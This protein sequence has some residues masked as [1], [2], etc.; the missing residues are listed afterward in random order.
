MNASAAVTTYQGLFDH[1]DQAAI[2]AD[3]RAYFG[4][5]ADRFIALYEKMR[6]REPAKRFGAR[7]WNWPAFFLTFVWF[8]YRRQW[9]YGIGV[10]VLNLV[11]AFVA[12]SA[13]GAIVGGMCGILA[14]TLYV[15]KAMMAVA[16]ADQAG[17]AGEARVAQL[18]AAGGVSKLAGGIAGFV[19]AALMALAVIGAVAG[20]QAAG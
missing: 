14:N 5:N 4:P 15:Q 19:L 20:Q 18:Q 8:F 16:A 6:G 13:A 3:L 12:G 2:Q 1:S 9:V 11:L 17:L 7:S 10:I